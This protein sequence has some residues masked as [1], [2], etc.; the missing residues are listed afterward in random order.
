MDVIQKIEGVL[1]CGLLD[2]EDLDFFE[3]LDMQACERLQAEIEIE[4]ITR[5]LRR[6]E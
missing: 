3:F 6:Y 2:E 4:R 5:E 1:E